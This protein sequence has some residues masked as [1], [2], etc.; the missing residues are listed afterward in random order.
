MQ[1]NENE[2]TYHEP[3]LVNLGDANEITPEEKLELPGVS[4]AGCW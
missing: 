4:G 1:P 3:V 2:E